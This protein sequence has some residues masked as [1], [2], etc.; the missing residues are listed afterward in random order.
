MNNAGMLEKI[1]FTERPQHEKEVNAILAAKNEGKI[2]KLYQKLQ[3]DKNRAEL[4]IAVGERLVELGETKL[5]KRYIGF[6]KKTKNLDKQVQREEARD[7][8]TREDLKN[9][10]S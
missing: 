9:L 3:N 5:G 10:L 6:G 2:L 7:R 4:Q 1:D 8:R